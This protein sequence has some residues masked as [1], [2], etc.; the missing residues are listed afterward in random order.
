MQRVR[1]ATPCT[2][3]LSDCAIRAA[4]V[5][6]AGRQAYCGAML[7]RASISSYS[8]SLGYPFEPHCKRLVADAAKTV[9]TAFHHQPTPPSVLR[10]KSTETDLM[11]DQLPF[12]CYHHYQRTVVD[13][14]PPASSPEPNPPSSARRRLA[15]PANDRY[16]VMTRFSFV[17]SRRLHHLP[18]LLRFLSPS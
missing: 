10:M 17:N 7:K 13:M 8:S 5:T 12:H 6:W 2:Y 4:A 1:V 18:Y 14:Q 9:A 11:L 16:P 3:T 15:V